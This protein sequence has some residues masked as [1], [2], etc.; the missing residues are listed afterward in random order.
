MP[1]LPATM[2]HFADAANAASILQHGLLSTTGLLH[3]RGVDAPI[4]AAAMTFRPSDIELPGGERVRNQAP[5]PPAALARCLDP[6]TSPDDWYRLV[7]GHV[8]FWLGAERME[9]HRVALRARDQILLTVDT[10]ALLAFYHDS[11]FVTPFNIGNA[12]RTP[13][14]RG[15]R[16]LCPLVSWRQHSWMLEAAAGERPRPASHR[17]AELLIK[18]AVPDVHRFIVKSEYI[19]AW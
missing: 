15:P 14:R 6:G 3:R 9:R 7:N 16:T 12:R 18:G 5:M 2:F 4:A 1:E 11:A 13:A 8:F 17:P 19:A 10:A